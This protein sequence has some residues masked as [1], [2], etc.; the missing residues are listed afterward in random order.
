MSSYIG[1]IIMKG[2]IHKTFCLISF[3]LQNNFVRWI[4]K[5][6]WQKSVNIIRVKFIFLVLLLFMLPKLSDLFN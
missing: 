2:D 5:K 4:K 6:D 1:F 3:T